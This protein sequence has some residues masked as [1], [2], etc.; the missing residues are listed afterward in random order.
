MLPFLRAASWQTVVAG[1][2]WHCSL[3]RVHDDRRRAA[4]GRTRTARG[5]LQA[6]A[7]LLCCGAS[8]HPICL[9]MVWFT[10]RALA[11]T[12]FSAHSLGDM[13]KHSLV[14][15]TLVLFARARADSAAVALPTVCV[16]KRR[17]LSCCIS[18]TGKPRHRF[19]ILPLWTWFAA[20]AAGAQAHRAT[21]TSRLD[22]ISTRRFLLNAEWRT[23][24]A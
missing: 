14:H 18:L 3:A 21:C 4:A 23:F 5:R 13:Q 24:T 16:S 2:R 22:A 1:R 20:R 8:G 7:A 15:I 10:L 9:P 12:L 11:R 6:H 19:G 17:R